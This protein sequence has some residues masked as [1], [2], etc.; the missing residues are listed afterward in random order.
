MSCS[1]EKLEKVDIIHDTFPEPQKELREVIN[2][3]GRDAETANLEGLMDI[4]LQSKKFTKFGPRSFERQDVDRTN[5][6]ESTH[7]G[8]LKNFKQEVKDLK[9]DVFGD[10]GIATYYPHVS[11]EKN[12]KENTGSARQTLVFLKTNEGWKI[13]HEHGRMRQE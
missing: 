11:F 5:E 3:I 4:H 8:S 2:A 9:I 1:T 13:V 7:Y 6:S 12:G 10:I